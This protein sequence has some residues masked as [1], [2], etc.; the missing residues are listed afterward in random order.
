MRDRLI[1]L[2]TDRIPKTDNPLR[3]VA[4]E[5]VERIV[6]YLLEN[7]V[8]VPPVKAGEKIYKLETQYAKYVKEETVE[9]NGVVYKSILGGYVLVPFED[10]GKTVF[11][12]KEEAQQALRGEG[13]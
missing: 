11:L 9:P 8:I 6:D 10:I 3:C 2:L 4:D 13:K 5:I 12:T 1:E 7:G